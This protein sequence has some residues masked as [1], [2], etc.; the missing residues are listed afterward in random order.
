MSV[1]ED[2]EIT[3]ALAHRGLFGNGYHGTA[4]QH[5]ID[6]NGGY[7]MGPHTLATIVD[8]NTVPDFIGRKPFTF[9]RRGLASRFTAR[10]RVSDKTQCLG[11]KRDRSARADRRQ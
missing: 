8:A 2:A 1:G 7:R 6:F 4:H 5:G 9:A 3:P 11:G 10:T